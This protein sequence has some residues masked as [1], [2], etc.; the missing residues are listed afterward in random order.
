MYF[1]LIFKITRNILVIL[2]AVARREISRVGPASRKRC[3]TEGFFSFGLAEQAT[4]AYLGY[5]RRHELMPATRP[6]KNKGIEKQFNF[7]N[8]LLVCLNKV[9]KLLKKS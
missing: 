3:A 9:K 5:N 2:V 4:G 1:M 6:F 7:N 8:K